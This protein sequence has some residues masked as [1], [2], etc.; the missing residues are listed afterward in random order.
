MGDA[1]YVHIRTPYVHIALLA[2]IA[3]HA[4]LAADMLYLAAY[5]HIRTRC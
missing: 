2:D 4:L 5:V 3:L 1:E